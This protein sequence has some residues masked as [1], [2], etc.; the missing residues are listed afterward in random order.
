MI[1]LDVFPK[2]LHVK[3]ELSMT[4]VNHV[5]DYLNRCTFDAT[6]KPTLSEDT[7]TYVEQVFFKE[8]DKLTESMK[9]QRE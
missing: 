6:I 7:K 3:L 4:Q 8:L 5:L 2:D 9:E 1:I